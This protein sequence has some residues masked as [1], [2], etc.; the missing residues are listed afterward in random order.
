M[1]VRIFLT[2]ILFGIS[3]LLFAQEIP[4]DQ[5]L[6][7]LT[8]ISALANPDIPK[9]LTFRIVLK[10]T[11][12]IDREKILLVICRAPG[13]R[14]HAVPAVGLHGA[15]QGPAAP[16]RGACRGSGAGPL[17]QAHRLDPAADPAGCIA[18]DRDGEDHGAGPGSG[19]R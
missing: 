7:S 16:V 14:Q 1:I 10:D 18:A 19:A 13:G 8:S 6:L 17:G 15:D 12:R 9:N 5:K 3:Q 4:N 2:A 11:V